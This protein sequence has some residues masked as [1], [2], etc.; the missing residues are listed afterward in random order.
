MHDSV[1]T[2]ALDQPTSPVA[3]QL[4]SFLQ[5]LLQ[6]PPAEQATALTTR[7]RGQPARLSWEQ[8]WLALLLAVLRGLTCWRDVWQLLVWEGVG[9]FPLVSVPPAAVRQR[10]LK[11]GTA[12]LEQLLERVN[13]AL[14]QRG[15]A[16]SALTLAP[17]ASQVV[18]L[19]ETTLDALHR[20]CPDLRGLPAGC[21]QLLVGKL[22]GLFDL[23]AQQWLRLQFREDVLANCKVGVL[24]LLEGLAPGSLIL[25]DLGYFSFPWFDYLTSQGYWWLAR[26]RERTSYRIVHLY[27][28]QGETLDALLWLGAYRADRAAHLV[29]LVQFRQGGHLCRYLTNVTDPALLSMLDMARLY[30]RRWDI[31]LAFKLLKR[32]LGLHLWW[33]ATPLLVLQQLLAALILAQLLHALHLEI[34]AQAQVDPFEVSLPIL[35]KLL[36][37]PPATTQPLVPLLVERGRLLGLIRPSTRLLVEAPAIPLE[38]LHPPPADLPT[39]RSARYAQ[40]KCHPRTSQPPHTPRFFT[41]LLI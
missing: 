20:W 31:E 1:P 28:Q 41:Q 26:L 17:F 2:Q 14:R 7:R 38:L 12:A 15:A 37:H 24:L 8:L 21:A 39:V 35:V 10:L 27:Y 23:R 16:T 5:A 11:A 9:N 29:R 22:A 3:Q 34:A 36:A 25:A 40:R 32:Q 33:A 18:A 19:D 13:A 6:P 30:A 4:V